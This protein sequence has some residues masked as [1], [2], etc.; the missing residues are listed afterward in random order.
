MAAPQAEASRFGRNGFSGNPDTNGGSDCTVCHAPGAPV[1]FVTITGPATVDAGT[2]NTYTVTIAGGP[3]VTGGLNV[4]VSDGIGELVPGDATTQ[5]IEGELAHTEPQAFSGGQLVFT[6][7]W[8]APN[9]DTDAILYAAGNSTTGNLDLAGDGVGT[10][11]LTIT[12]ING[13]EDPPPPPPPPNPSVIELV[14]LAGGFNAPVALAN[15]GDERLFVAEQRGKVRLIDGNGQV[16]PADFLD[17]EDRVKFNNSE[18][19]LLGIAFHPDYDQNGFFYVNYIFDPGPG[20]DRTRVSRFQVTGDPNVADPN[21]ELVL[22]EFEQDFSNHNGGDLKFGPDGFL[23]IAS[24]DG[25]SGG[26]PNDRAQSP[27]TLMGKILRID[28]DTPPGPGNSPDCTLVSE[29]N[30]AIPASNAFNDGAG[31]AGCDEIYALGI[32]NPWRISFDRDTGD[33]WI[34]DVGQND[35]EEIDFVTA[36]AGG[37]LN[38]GWRCFEGSQ[39]FDLSDCNGS[40]VDPVFEYLH[41]VDGNCSVTGGFVY[42]GQ[43]FPAI[44]G[45][46]FFSDFCNSSIRS[47]AGPVNDLIETVVLPAGQVLFTTFGEDNRGELYGADFL[48]GTIFQITAETVED[49]PGDV[50]G[51]GDVDRVD[52]RE[53]F[54]ALGTLADGPDDPRDVDGNGFITRADLR[55]AVQNCTNPG[56]AVS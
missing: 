40:Y 54:L 45:Q 12:V 27:V 43:D 30:Y 8:T 36:G 21:S 24:G 4:S 37:G 11:S 2:S 49:I 9:Y 35:V 20:L 44:Q 22:V 6:F 7:D 46:Y 53:I 18:E 31:G 38:F 48:S 47:L 5:I 29:A 41:A 25:G 13:F 33:L 19:G 42:R 3:G 32:R 50:D 26:D 1:P 34:G 39:E 51:D 14:A 10:N 55:D 15:A 28:V 56:C 23:Y 17:I 52:L 16:P